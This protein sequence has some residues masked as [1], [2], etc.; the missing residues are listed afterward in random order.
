MQLPFGLDAVYISPFIL[1]GYI[2]IGASTK[3]LLKAI[4][5][6]LAWCIGMNLLGIFMGPDQPGSDF[7]VVQVL[8]ATF[9]TAITFGIAVW[10]R[11]RRM[12][13]S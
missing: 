12:A 7:W 9:T 1:G 5:L 2:V 10:L 8:V 11:R 3:K 13:G 6:A 4:L